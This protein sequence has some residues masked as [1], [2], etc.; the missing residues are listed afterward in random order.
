MI[1]VDCRVAPVTGTKQIRCNACRSEY[2]RVYYSQ[3]IEIYLQRM[4]ASSR[5]RAKTKGAPNDLTLDQLLDLW[6]KQDGRCALSGIA[7]TYE[8]TNG[9]NNAYN[10][11]LD[12][13]RPGLAYTLKNV[14]LVT[15]RA[16]WI[17]GD[18]DNSG[19]NWW[20]TT[21]HGHMNPK[22]RKPRC[23]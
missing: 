4:L 6:H 2:N 12:R 14:Q 8:I 10:A 20:V 1:C 9:T 22:K 3:S 16:N 7:M 18:L 15:A 13:I 5:R 21:I 19:I 11:S 23:K 17:K